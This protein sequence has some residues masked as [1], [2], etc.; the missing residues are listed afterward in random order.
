MY[1][2][3]ERLISLFVRTCLRAWYFEL[4]ILLYRSS[5]SNASSGKGADQP[6]KWIVRDAFGLQNVRLDESVARQQREGS[7]GCQSP[8]RQRAASS[9]C[10]AGAVEGTATSQELFFV[11]G[12]GYCTSGP[13]FGQTSGGKALKSPFRVAENLPE[14]RSLRAPEGIPAETRPENANTGSRNKKTVPGTP[15]GTFPKH[16]ASGPDFGRIVGGCA[17][18]SA[19]QPAFGR[20]EGPFDRL[21]D[22][23]P[24]K[25]WSGVAMFHNV[26]LKKSGGSASA[27]S[28]CK[29]IRWVICAETK[30]IHGSPGKKT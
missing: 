2:G 14:E 6:R 15:L 20:P 28:L 18:N 8:E 30:R 27:H 11:P 13:G 17:L 22:E 9:R 5:F 4:P 16:R 10:D 19:F 7:E 29:P 23:T 25:M 3:G 1:T 12:A 24:T 26:S 21:P